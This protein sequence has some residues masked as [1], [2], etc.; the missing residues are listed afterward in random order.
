MLILKIIVTKLNYCVKVVLFWALNCDVTVQI[1]SFLCFTVLSLID[2]EVLSRRNYCTPKMILR[3]S[4]SY[5]VVSLNNRT[6]T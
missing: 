2:P 6:M 1:R 3:S 5:Y 4:D